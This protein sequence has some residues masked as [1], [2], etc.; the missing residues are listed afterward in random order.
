MSLPSTLPNDPSI[1]TCD[2]HVATDS[3]VFIRLLDMLITAYVNC[4]I[5]VLL[6]QLCYSSSV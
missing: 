4:S 1:G 2:V 6:L 3:H 5:L